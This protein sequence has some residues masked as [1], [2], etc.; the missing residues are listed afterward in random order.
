MLV[1]V[2]MQVCMPVRMRVRMAVRLTGCMAV[3]VIA[4]GE[5]LKLNS[6]ALGWECRQAESDPPWR[7][8]QLNWVRLTTI[9]LLRVSQG[10]DRSGKCL[11]AQAVTGRTQE[12]V[13]C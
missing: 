9:R 6:G 2:E 5:I 8:L 12:M 4:H 1:R 13:S 10:G 11:V 7:N 3:I